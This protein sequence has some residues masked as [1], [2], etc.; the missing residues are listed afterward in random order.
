MQLVSDSVECSSGEDP[1]ASAIME[2]G[3]VYFVD[4][5]TYI[6]RIRKYH[7]Y[8]QSPFKLIALLL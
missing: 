8:F 1:T 6:M 4:R 2:D 7:S 5:W 3:V